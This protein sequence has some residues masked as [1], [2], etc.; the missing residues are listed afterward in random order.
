MTM[1]ANRPHTLD[2]SGYSEIWPS[3]PETA[4]RARKWVKA[5]MN[6][7]NLDGDDIERAALIVSELVTN[8]V[9]HSQCPLLRV[10][11]ARCGPDSVR[12]SVADRSTDKP[13]V[14]AAGLSDESGRGL[15]LVRS[16]ADAWDVEIRSTGKTVY[17][18]LFVEP[19][20]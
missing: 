19:P 11:V 5:A 1:T 13:E 12:I 15:V 6:T 8:S 3:E 14:R 10:G 18:D 2:A 16:L 20:G 9:L 7:W 17:A 4:G